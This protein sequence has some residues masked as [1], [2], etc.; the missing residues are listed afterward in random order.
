M[1]KWTTRLLCNVLAGLQL[2]ACAV[3]PT[4]P[5]Q[6]QRARMTRM[7]IV[8]LPEPPRSNFRA[9]VSDH[10]S[11]ARGAAP[12]GGM[13]GALAGVYAGMGPLEAAIA[14]YLAVVAIPVGMA[15][16]ALTADRPAMTEAQA[17]ELEAEVNRN[18]AAL[19]VSPT[20]A[21]QIAQTAKQDVGL[22]LPLL[23]DSGPSGPG[24]R[25][26]YR[27][28]PGHDSV[29]EVHVTDAGFSGAGELS[30]YLVATIRIIPTDTGQPSYERQFAYQSD[31][32]KAGLWGEHHAALFR[33]E[34]QRAHDSLAES[35]VEQLYLL[36][37]L[38]LETKAAARADGGFVDLLGGRNACGLA[39]ISPERDYHPG[40]RDASHRDWN[41]YPTVDSLR[42][43][44]AW[45]AF[46]RAVD[47]QIEERRGGIGNVRY[48]LRVWEVLANRPPRLIYERRDL[49]NTSHVLE[50]A[51]SPDR[52]YY[53]SARARFDL[54]GGVHATKWGYFQTPM[55]DARDKVKAAA[56]PGV[57]LGVF[58]AGS[59]P[60]DVCTLDFIPTS[61]YYRFRTPPH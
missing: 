23:A 48:D 3:L 28:L 52:P 22:D 19:Q 17:A 25:P 12:G 42:P 54:A 29:M 26:G 53:W 13:S 60:R 61:N 33:D 47:K 18:L 14:P 4:P 16:G 49:K 46:P 30:L 20:L 11:L 24:A 2:T 5:A 59:A 21:R 34:L 10:L 51:L 1:A 55:Y 35:A 37:E 50:Q 36:T 57:I 38:P 39:W 7:A 32:Y 6:E 8:T 9:F 40:I 44:L 43:T 41:R 27:T 45:E 56:S 15:V 58:L 31:A